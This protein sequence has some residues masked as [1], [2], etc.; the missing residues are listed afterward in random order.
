MIG[1]NLAITPKRFVPLG[2]AA[3]DTDAQAF[4]TAAGITD[5]TQQS[6]VNQLVLD[7]KSANIWTKMKAIYPI[8]AG[9]ASTHKWNL[10]D[11]RDLDA[12]YR[13]TFA[14]G[15]THS[16]NGMT[17]NGTSAFANTFLNPNSVLSSSDNHLSIYLRTNVQATTVDFGSYSISGL[18]YYLSLYTRNV[19]NN[20]I[21]A[22]GNTLFPSSANADSRGFF[23]ISKPTSSNASGFRNNIK[24]INNQAVGTGITSQNMY[25][26]ASNNNGTAGTFSNRQIAFASLGNSLTDTEAGNFYT[27]VQA[28]QT[29]LS[30]NV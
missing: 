27:A 12:A 13:L 9:T 15:W 24:L 3:I 30:R 11:P 28:F 7:L 6:A 22:N 5:G 25:L 2:G 19:S 23:L 8:L 14:T 16:S 17:G 4:I 26:G 18:T 10:K 29:T 20:M 1:T 21:I